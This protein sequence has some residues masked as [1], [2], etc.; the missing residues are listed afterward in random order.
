MAEA[1][2]AATYVDEA[3]DAT[4]LELAAIQLFDSCSQICCSL[5]L[6]KAKGHFVSSNRMS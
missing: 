5:E 1:V 4:S 2:V 6:D 3:L